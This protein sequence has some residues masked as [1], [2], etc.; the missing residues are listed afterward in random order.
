VP[1]KVDLKLWAGDSSAMFDRSYR[2]DDITSYRGGI[3]RAQDGQSIAC[4][5][6]K[7]DEYVC[8]TYADLKKV[9]DAM[10]SCQKWPAQVAKMNNVEMNKAI[11]IYGDVSSRATY[12]ENQKKKVRR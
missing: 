6:V 10:W 3:T 5:N 2:G 9:M 4:D 1:P 7:I 11:Q 12:I 8:M